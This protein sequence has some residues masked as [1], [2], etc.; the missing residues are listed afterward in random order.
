MVSIR[1][2]ISELEKC[3]QLRALTR[4]C[5]LSAIH[6]FSQYALELDEGITGALRNH[7]AELA[8]EV[9]ICEAEGISETRATLRGVLRDYRDKASAYLNQLR[10]ELS[11]NAN[12]LQRLVESLTENDG[13]HE[14]K[15]RRA[16][17]SLRWIPRRRRLHRSFVRVEM[18][19]SRLLVSFASKI[20]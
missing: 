2:S 11:Q 10:E 12:G 9:E 4:E 1:A 3:E 15:L 20:S 17:G 8:H 6:N 13:D 5:Y 18:P 16:L 7:L 19:S 14:S